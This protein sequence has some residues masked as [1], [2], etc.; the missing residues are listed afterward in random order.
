M[1][2]LIDESGCS[3]FK[4]G[5]GSTPFFVIGM[6]T[7]FDFEEAE[8]ASNKISE[9][10]TKLNIWPE[11][12]FSK[13]HSDVKDIFFRELCKFNFNVQAL[14]VEKTNLKNIKPNP[15]ENFYSFLIKELIQKQDTI[16]AKAIIK[17]DGN[18]DKE[19][20]NALNSYLRQQIGSRK[21]G[22]FRFVD[23]QKDN[24]IQLADMTV[25]AIARHQNQNRKESS[26]W[27]KLLNSKI[28]DIWNYN[29]SGFMP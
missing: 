23:S 4:L 14:V 13:T 26:R 29:Q 9:L 17:I 7:F 2:V 16:L 5:K 1:L 27:Y 28:V 19:F 3:G 8:K 6:V 15:K 22:K 20:K 11:F 24:L 18:G 10:R 25:G 12:K 21:I